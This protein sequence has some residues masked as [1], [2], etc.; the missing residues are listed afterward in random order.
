MGIP[1]ELELVYAAVA[2]QHGHAKKKLNWFMRPSPLVI[3]TPK[4]LELVHAAVAPD[5]EK[6]ERT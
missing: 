1:K 3:S 4:E 2:P 6:A 5:H